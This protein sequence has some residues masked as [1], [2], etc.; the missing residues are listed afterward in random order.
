MNPQVLRLLGVTSIVLMGLIALLLVVQTQHV[1]STQTPTFERGPIDGSPSDDGAHRV[2]V[3]G[4]ALPAVSLP[5][6]GVISG[7]LVLTA[8][9]TANVYDFGIIYSHAD[10]IVAMTKFGDDGSVIQD[11]F[12][13]NV[14]THVV[15]T[16][17]GSDSIF[18]ESSGMEFDAASTSALGPSMSRALAGEFQQAQITDTILVNNSE[19]G[20]IVEEYYG[21]AADHVLWVDVQSLLPLRSQLDLN[22]GL[23]ISTVDEFWSYSALT[24]Q[25]ISVADVPESLSLDPEYAWTKIDHELSQQ[26]AAQFDNYPI[27]WS[28]D[29]ISTYAL[30][31]PEHRVESSEGL[32]TFNQEMGFTNSSTDYVE[33]IYCENPD[34]GE[35]FDN[36][37]LVTSFADSN[38]PY[39][40]VDADP[41]YE[42]I[43]V[44]SF[45]AYVRDYSSQL[46]YG[47][48]LEGN[49]GV[50][51]VV[52]VPDGNV[53][54]TAPT[55]QLADL[56]GSQLVQLNP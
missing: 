26:T 3:S 25:D 50:E 48:D 46:Q 5:F 55:R 15:S 23:D 41:D 24:E 11:L 10:Q 37:I 16:T 35:C 1:E 9:T 30:E 2:P 7:T 21:P 54:I 47:I 39:S 42:Q 14:Y 27:Y 38:S 51:I 20:R 28:G 19:Q 18:T 44:Q 17:T 31:R 4:I 33:Y 56:A 6:E 29:D 40:D 43:A 32:A 8:G 36:Q 52:I 34:P 22:E 49:D 45:V 53:V 12:A 13:E